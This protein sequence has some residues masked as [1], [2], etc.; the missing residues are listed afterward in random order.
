MIEHVLE[1]VE[2]AREDRG[3][4]EVARARRRRSRRRPRPGVLAH[5]A[6]RH[7]HREPDREGTDRQR[8]AA[9]V[10]QQRCPGEPLLEPDE[11]RERQTRRPGPSPA[12]R[13]ARR[14]P[15]RAG[16]RT[17]GGPARA[18]VSPAPRGQMSRPDD[19]DERE[20]GDEPAQPGSA[21][22][23]QVQASLERL[24]RRDP[25]GPSRR[26]DGGRQR[27]DDADGERPRGRR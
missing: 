26:L 14:A 6:E 23:R 22:G 4:D 8:R 2:A 27:H 18:A 3:E 1:L 5:A 10:A 17:R 13:T 15:R 21:R 11:Q 20:H 24:D 7:D 19:A 12:G 16:R 25:T 9:A